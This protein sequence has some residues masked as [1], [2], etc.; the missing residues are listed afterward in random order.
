[1]LDQRRVG[2]VFRALGDPTRR[3]LV[4]RLGRGAATASQLAAPLPIS[5][6][7]VIQHLQ[8]LE[9]SGVVRSQK[10]GRV[11]TC[12]LK[13]EGL[14]LAGKWLADRTGLGERRLNRPGALRAESPKRKGRKRK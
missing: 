11:R 8:I 3:A 2:L 5:L 14:R 13:P 10:A 6:A 12:S 1:M 4:E 9:E 7:A